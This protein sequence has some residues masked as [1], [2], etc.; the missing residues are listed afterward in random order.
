MNINDVL[1]IKILPQEVGG[2]YKFNAQVYLSRGFKAAYKDDFEFVVISS[3]NLI[4]K[5]RVQTIEGADYLQ[6]FNYRGMRYWCIDD[7]DHITFLLPE[8]Y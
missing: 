8:E 1:K 3:L 6:S 2:T 4:Y 5:N 7:I